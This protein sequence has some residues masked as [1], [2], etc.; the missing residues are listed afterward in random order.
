LYRDG[1]SP[2]YVAK[3]LKLHPIQVAIICGTELPQGPHSD[4]RVACDLHRIDL[5]RAG[6]VNGSI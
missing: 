6:H 4:P 3:K 5:M 1:R 2:E